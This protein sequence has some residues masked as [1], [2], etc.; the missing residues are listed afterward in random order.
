MEGS[1]NMTKR[2][3]IN[4]FLSY[5][6]HDSVELKLAHYLHLDLDSEEMYKLK[7][8]GIF[9]NEPVG[10]KKPATPAQMLQKIL[11]DR[12]GLDA[13]D[14]DMLVMW[15]RFN[16]E[17][18]GKQHEVHASM[19]A[20]GEDHVHTAMAKTV[21]LP[22]AIAVR[23]IL[24]GNITIRGVQIPTMAAVYN[25]VLDALQAEGIIFQERE[26]EPTFY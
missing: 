10:L 20:L 4:S 16:Y 8:L 17:L 6:L 15:H 2:E 13:D 23:L 11:E 7:W 5:N 12:W 24:N 1:E 26:V 3:F 18:N 19:V 9:D 25:P 21:G 14:K 22:V